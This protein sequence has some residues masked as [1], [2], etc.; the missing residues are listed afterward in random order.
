[1]IITLDV[2]NEMIELFFTFL[3]TKLTT[4]KIISKEMEKE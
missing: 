4:I 3:K 2:P 1:M